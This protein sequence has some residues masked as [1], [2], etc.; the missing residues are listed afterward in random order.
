MLVGE[1]LKAIRG[2]DKPKEALSESVFGFN[3][4]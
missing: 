2:F 4:C 3:L 1:P